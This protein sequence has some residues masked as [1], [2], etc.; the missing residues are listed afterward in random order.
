MAKTFYC[1]DWFGADTILQGG[2]DKDERVVGNN[3]RLIRLSDESI[4]LRLHSTNIVTYHQDGT[5][6]LYMGGWDTVITKRAI[7]DYS[8]ARVYSA[9]GRVKDA[10]G[11][12]VFTSI[13]HSSD[14]LT[15]PK[16]QKCRKCHGT[17][18]IVERCD[19]RYY[20]GWYHRDRTKEIVKALPGMVYRDVRTGYSWE[21]CDIC[22]THRYSDCLH[23]PGFPAHTRTY[24]ATVTRDYRERHPHNPCAHGFL[25]S[26]IHRY[27]CHACDA[28]GQRDYG[29]R[30]MPTPFGRHDQIRVAEDGKV[31]G[32]EEEVK[33]FLAYKHELE[34]F[35]DYRA[36]ILLARRSG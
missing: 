17:G 33:E 30:V 2:R 36:G 8:P 6:T 5:C 4:A 18:E 25:E 9:G 34:T 10:E 16:I 35:Y 24:H 19:G 26:H 15:P 22:E 12:P 32:M 7:N 13:W 11:F 23:A 21:D 31:L 20:Y 28:T 14:G 27:A 29:S 1:T 3:R